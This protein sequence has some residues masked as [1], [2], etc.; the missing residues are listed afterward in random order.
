[1]LE[2]FFTKPLQGAL[3]RFFRD[4]IMGYT[5]IT[6]ILDEQPKIKE[7]VENWRKYKIKMIS[8]IDVRTDKDR[9]RIDKYEGHEKPPNDAKNKDTNNKFVHDKAVRSTYAQVTKRRL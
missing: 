2:D 3:F 6:D 7:R 5:S 1:M 4:I 9:V 8:N